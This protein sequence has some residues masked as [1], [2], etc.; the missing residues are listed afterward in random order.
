[1]KKTKKKPVYFEDRFTF[2]L[3]KANITFAF[4]DFRRYSAMLKKRFGYEKKRDREPGGNTIRMIYEEGGKTKEEFF[5]WL[6]KIDYGCLAHEATHLAGY[7]FEARGIETRPE[8]E[9]EPFA[10]FVEWLV[11]DYL[12]FVKYFKKKRKKKK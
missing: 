7:I 3:Y 11:N 8:G 6:S 10:F 1:M 9:D 2:Y 4:G 5:L 12:A